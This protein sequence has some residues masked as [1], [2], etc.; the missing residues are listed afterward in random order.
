MN[1][2]ERKFDSYIDIRGENFKAKALLG[3]IFVFQA[4]NFVKFIIAR[5][6]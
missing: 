4:V 2:T 3:I 5:Y 1:T 6:T